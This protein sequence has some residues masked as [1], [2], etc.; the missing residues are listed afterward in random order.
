MLI[1]ELN[2]SYKVYEKT[3]D[4]VAAFSIESIK[5][6]LINKLKFIVCHGKTHLSFSFCPDTHDII[7]ET[8]HQ[9]L[10]DE[11]LE[12][13]VSYTNVTKFTISGW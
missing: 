10:L 11:G 8:I 6:K 4:H 1:N 3:Y 9:W 7:I 2:Q 12:V 5:D 13:D